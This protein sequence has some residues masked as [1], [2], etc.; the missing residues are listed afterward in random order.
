MSVNVGVRDT[1]LTFGGRDEHKNC[2]NNQK[3]QKIIKKTTT[4]TTANKIR[5]RN[6]S[7]TENHEHETQP[8]PKS[9]HNTPKHSKTTVFYQIREKKDTFSTLQNQQEVL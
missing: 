7:T 2:K 1:I 3:Q 4:I 9:H 8:Q 5:N 6:I